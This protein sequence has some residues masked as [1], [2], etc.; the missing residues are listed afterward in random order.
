M[1]RFSILVGEKLIKGQ[2]SEIAMAI[3]DEL[4][5]W[6]EDYI[7][8]KDLL[9]KS[10]TSIQRNQGGWNLVV[11]RE[12]GNQEFLILPHLESSEQ[13]TSKMQPDMNACLVVLNT[14]ANLDILVKQWSSFIKFPKLCIIFA[15]PKS[16]TEKRWII[17]PYTHNKVTEKGTLK[18]GLESLFVMV[19][20][21]VA[22]T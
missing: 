13:L 1:L 17:F 20:P 19:E 22:K 4:T 12:S 2:N 18:A 21:Y 6:T 10:V 9:T 16:M 14:R 8:N 11:I 5:D 7:K 15:N 3:L